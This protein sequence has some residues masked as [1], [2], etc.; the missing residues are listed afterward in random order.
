LFGR[1]CLCVGVAYFEGGIL[2]CVKLWEERFDRVVMLFECG[3]GF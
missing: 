1:V 3:G 2:G